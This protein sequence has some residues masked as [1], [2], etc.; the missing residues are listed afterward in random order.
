[1]SPKAALTCCCSMTPDPPSLP[2][3]AALL[4]SLFWWVVAAAFR[5][6]HPLSRPVQ[7]GAF[8]GWERGGGGPRGAVA[9]Q[10]NQALQAFDAAFR[11]PVLFAFA[12]RP[13][14]VG[15]FVGG[16]GD[17]CRHIKLFKAGIPR[18]SRP[19]LLLLVLL[20]CALSVHCKQPQRSP[21][22]CLLLLPTAAPAPCPAPQDF[23]FGH[24]CR[25]Y[26]SV[27][28]RLR[29]RARDH[30]QQVGGGGAGWEGT[31]VQEL[32]TVPQHILAQSQGKPLV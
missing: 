2:C 13:V 23:T 19:S 32:N 24:F 7:V 20:L 17:V 1:M 9:R 6:D 25:H 26:V 27:V 15:V 22:R 14:Q 4:V 31:K 8:R 5:P 16:K 29:G 28:L 10:A 3:P 11:R 30:Y 21:K 12:S 18:P